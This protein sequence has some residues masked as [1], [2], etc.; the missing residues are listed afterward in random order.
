MARARL[1]SSNTPE[2]ELPKAKINKE[3]YTRIVRSF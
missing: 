1:N 3:S 2:E